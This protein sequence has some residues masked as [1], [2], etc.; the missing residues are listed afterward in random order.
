MTNHLPHFH[1]STC[2]QQ[3]FSHFRPLLYNAQVEA[4]Y[5][6]LIFTC[7]HCVQ[8]NMILSFFPQSPQ[9]EPTRLTPFFQPS[10]LPNCERTHFSCFVSH[11]LVVHYYDSPREIIT[12]AKMLILISS[13]G[14]IMGRCGMHHLL[15]NISTMYSC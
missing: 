1:W 2:K 10:R 14:W 12:V 6:I 15:Q 3:V 8:F 9:E 7:I 11:Q 5:I 4:T 13:P